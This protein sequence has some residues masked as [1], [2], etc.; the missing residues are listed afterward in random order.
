MLNV[1]HLLNRIAIF[2]Q[3]N[4]WAHWCIFQSWRKFK[5]LI[6]SRNWAVAFTA[7]STFSLLWNWWHP[8]C[9][10]SG[11]NK[12]TVARCHPSAWQCNHR[13]HMLDKTYVA[14]ISLWTPWLHMLDTKYVAVISP[15]TPWTS[16]LLLWLLM[17]HLAC[18]WLHRN[19]EM[20]MVVHK[21]WLEQP[22]CC[23]NMMFKPMPQWGNA[24]MCSEIMLRS[25]GNFMEQMSCSWF[26][27]GFSLNFLT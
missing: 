18:H 19:E 24:L 10:F 26:G 23:C 5:N 8:K 14:V 22:H 1:A 11:P 27:N 20:V 12:G 21:S 25:N 7:I 4:T 9:Y 6:C 16:T 13:Q 15:W 17:Q 3:H 2:F